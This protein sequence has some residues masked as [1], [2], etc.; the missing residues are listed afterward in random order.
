M[1]T[2]NNQIAALSAAVGAMTLETP[3]DQGLNLN[4]GYVVLPRGTHQSPSLRWDS[5]LDTG[6]YSSG[7][8]QVNICANGSEIA[9]FDGP[10]TWNGA[11]ASI[12]FLPGGGSEPVSIAP[13]QNQADAHVDLA[14][15]GLRN[16]TVRIN[17][18]KMP[19]GDG[20]TNGKFVAY[21]DGALVFVDAPSVD[22][23]AFVA[24]SSKGVANGVA[25]LGSDGKVP[26]SQLPTSTGGGGGGIT[27]LVEDTAPKLGGSL[28]V[29]GKSITSSTSTRIE[30]FQHV[31]IDPGQN[32]YFGSAGAM[33]QFNVSV[34]HGFNINGTLYKNFGQQPV[35]SSTILYDVKVD[36]NF[37]PTD[38][39]HVVSKGYVDLA[40][41][42]G[43]G[44]GGGSGAELWTAEAYAN[45]D[46]N[47]ITRVSDGATGIPVLNG[48]MYYIE[49]KLY[50][51]DDYGYNFYVGTTR[52]M[53][54][55]DND[56]PQVIG[57]GKIDTV[58]V[59]S[60]QQFQISMWGD[61][62]KIVIGVSGNST[63]LIRWK[64]EITTKK[65]KG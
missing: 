54:R 48:E 65:L 12:Q 20:V 36:P 3:D 23:S 60:D 27:A 21:Q 33:R 29:N 43:G 24:T 59:A 61:Y 44:G 35:L 2:I 63:N 55:A 41:Q 51:T 16:G 8:N 40:V 38:D 15:S 10:T 1:L 34:L 26:V 56:Y 57:S 49:A 19:K 28:D 39:A 18:I 25:S 52:A 47:P 5:D 17:G 58:H 53:V 4:V 62:Q 30:A 64:V 7:D 14:L 45:Y 42:A 31:Y 6:L 11:G 37:T 32:M 22:T 50:G 9:R 13:Y 46:Q